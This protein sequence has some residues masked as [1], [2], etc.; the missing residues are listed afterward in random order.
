MAEEL[1]DASKLKII[2]VEI[3]SEMK[4]SYID[5]A[6][7]VIVGRALPDVR[8]GLKP[9]HRRI[10]YAMYED[11]I[12][13]D[14]AYKKCAATVGNVLGR[15]HP[16]GDSSVYD[17]LVRMAQDFSLRY[18]MVD[19]HGNF[20]SV[21]GDG[22]A[23][24]RYTEARMSKLAMHMLTDIEK[25]TVDFMP[26]FDE[27]RK[28][29]V[30]LPSR[31]P[32]L[33]VNGSNGIAV[34]MATNIPPHNLTE[35]VNG[36]IALI[37][38]PEIS[39]DELMEY[40][41][42]PDFPTGGQIMGVSGIRAAYHTGRGKLRVRAR[43]NIED[44]KDNRQ[45]IIVTE[46]PY[47]VNKARLIEKIAELV[48]DKRVE[49]I[50]DLRDESDRDGM[51][52]VIELKRDANATI[53]LNQLYKYTQMEDTFSVIMLALVNLTDPK[54]LNL[55][56]VLVQYLDFQKDVIVRRTR[57]DKKKAEARAHILEGLN[58]A[59]D[60]IDEVI[61][62]I[63]SSYNDAKEKLI[64]RFGFTDV[65]AQAILDMRLARLSGLEREKIENEYH[66]VKAL[67]AHL[68]EILGSEQM[69]L[70]I[71]KEE[72]GAIRDK[73]GDARRTTIE[74]VADDI[75]IEDLIEEE[76]NV[77]TLTH[78]GYIKRLAADTYKSQR[79]GGKGIIGLQT[80]EEDFVSTM[81]V[82]STH[83][84]IMF[85]TN[86][87]RMYRIKAYEIPEGSRT[88]KGTAVVNL[89]ALEPGETISAVIP[90]KE[91]EE[92]KYLV[93]CTRG[94]V[95]KKTDL[96]EYK[97]APKG[98]KIAIHLD[99]GDELIRVKLT[100]G[101]K[102]LFIGSHMG[103][104]IRFHESD[105]RCMGRVS[106][107][108]RAIDL[109]DGDYV[110]GMSIFR[111]DG[112]MLVVSEK[113]YGKKTEL[114]EYKCQTRGGKGCSTYKINDVTGAVAGIKVVSPEDDVILITSE[115]II[116]RMDT[117]E[118]S[119]YGRVTR[120]VRLMRLADG[121]SVVTVARV[122]KEQDDEDAAEPEAAESV[123]EQE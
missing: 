49:G 97:N 121:V 76:D 25:D 37:D 39:I 24:Y 86:T 112:K 72:I 107:G 84:H 4:K 63:R 91:Y 30:V 59:L 50:S 105:V 116:I 98:G 117:E 46:I 36:I 77:I 85:F 100:D 11:G 80:K 109:E 68:T 40:I 10:L 23:A 48:H 26:N 17:A 106:R 119:T 28:E 13:P 101:T 123:T 32:H 120:G 47:A 60:H 67:I 16:H 83:A 122:E 79:R 18:P 52:I 1:F 45:R 14:K 73:F 81:F 38:N 54:V 9:V 108:V 104:M 21:D 88:A 75:D 33:L 78:Q 3:N 55:K 69:V 93:M 41:P 66:E 74:P 71:I 94:G 29:P 58:L 27:S 7:S 99:E 118:I 15:Y 89:L 20:G 34:G 70:D 87:G 62:I 115:G 82:S 57:F 111:E 43:A 19:G 8:D 53:I 5:Y 22:A 113:G 42:G 56:E 65:Q 95:I 44:W 51:R 61:S 35:V 12:T 103:K 2:P 31:F 6:M 102:D 64:E 96:M 90:V 110:V 92:G 114:S